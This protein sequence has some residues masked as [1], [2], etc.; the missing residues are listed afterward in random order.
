MM[1]YYIMCRRT[2]DKPR[3]IRVVIVCCRDRGRSSAIR[4]RETSLV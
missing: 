2:S 3:S 1:P 4:K